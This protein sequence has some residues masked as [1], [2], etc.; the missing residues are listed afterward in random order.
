MT[1]IDW[2]ILGRRILVAAVLLIALMTQQ[3]RGEVGVGPGP[4]DGGAG[5][6]KRQFFLSRGSNRQQISEVF[7]Q[8]VE[9]ANSGAKVKLAVQGLTSVQSKIIMRALER[10]PWRNHWQRIVE[11]AL[12]YDPSNPHLKS[13]LL[14]YAEAELKS[15]LQNIALHNNLASLALADGD[16]D[17]LVK[18]YFT[19]AHKAAQ[20]AAYLKQFLNTLE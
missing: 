11:I 20:H 17:K 15:N 6:V 2:L 19:S 13:A 3:V 4:G 8:A 9:A 14:E 16:G 10:G 5:Q 12:R 7:R 1:G 18:H